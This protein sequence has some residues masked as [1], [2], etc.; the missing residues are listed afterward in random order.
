MPA[1][2][3][4]T[5]VRRVL[6]SLRE[7]FSTI[8]SKLCKSY[9]VWLRFGRSGA[10]LRPS[11]ERFNAAGYSG[12]IPAELFEKLVIWQRHAL[13]GICTPFRDMKSQFAMAAM[14][15]VRDSAASGREVHFIG[16]K[17]ALANSAQAA[18]GPQ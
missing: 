5:L 18:R 13:R 6:Q 17:P 7:A 15:P 9:T 4:W 12:A 2:L 14:S 16:L 11:A 8:S 10:I 1:E 3:A